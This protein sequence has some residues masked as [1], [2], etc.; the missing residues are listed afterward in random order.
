MR[1][2]RAL[3]LGAGLVLTTLGC[4][5]TM[6]WT[7]GVCDCNPPPVETLLQPYHPHPVATAPLGGVPHVVGQPL[8][9]APLMTPGTVPVQPMP[10]GP[11]ASPP[12]KPTEKIPVAPKPEK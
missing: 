8:P 12:V 3:L 2:L 9:G 5:R 4:S 10:A 1:L 6:K 11:Q 7:Q